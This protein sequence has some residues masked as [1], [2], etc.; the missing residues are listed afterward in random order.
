M[1]DYDMLSNEE[2]AKRK[3]T[4]Y[5]QKKIREQVNKNQKSSRGFGYS[6][7]SISF[8]VEEQ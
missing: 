7:K 8:D 1:T 6:Y 4:E 3:K 5:K 2:Y